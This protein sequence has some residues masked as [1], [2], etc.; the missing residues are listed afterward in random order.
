MLPD[1]L[2]GYKKSKISIKGNM[3]PIIHPYPNSSVKGLVLSVTHKEL[4][5]IDKYET[6]AYKRKRV[7]LKSGKTAW[8]YQ[9]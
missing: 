1:I 4:K 8:A 3:Y 6:N 7:A 5:P 2:D 9:K